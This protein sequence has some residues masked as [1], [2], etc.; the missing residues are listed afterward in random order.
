MLAASALGG[1]ALSGT[2]MA[3][4]PSSTKG[5]A[6]RPRDDQ[7]GQAKRTGAAAKRARQGNGVTPAQ[8]AAVLAMVK[9]H[10]AD[11][12]SLLTRLKKTSPAQYT[13]AVRSLFR[14]S[15]RLA[16]IQERDMARY[17]LELEKWKLESRV[18][19]LGLK[20]V[21]DPGS[22]M[23]ADQLRDS[24]KQLRD[25]KLQLLLLERDRQQQR[26]AK[27]Q[28]QIDNLGQRSPQQLEQELNAVLKSA[29]ALG[30]QKKD[31][32]PAKE[33]PAKDAKADTPA[34]QAR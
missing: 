7:D 27:L 20:A 12:E 13:Q 14:I 22:Q 26:L 16:A 33:T 21:R 31:T 24:L 9:Q 3:Q 1:L 17:E 18:Q 11:L 5:P 2:A 32:T 25:A 29:T 15:V 34:G 8:E 6:G 19:L 10:H 28:A 4:P 30:R 23:I